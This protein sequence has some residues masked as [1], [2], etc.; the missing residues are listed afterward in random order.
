MKVNEKIAI[1]REVP[2]DDVNDCPAYDRDQTIWELELLQGIYDEGLTDEFSRALECLVGEDTWLTLIAGPR[3]R[4]M[5]LEV[6]LDD[7]LWDKTR[8]NPSLFRVIRSLE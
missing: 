5:A 4:A 7:V 8:N 3:M 1:W 6:V 2:Y